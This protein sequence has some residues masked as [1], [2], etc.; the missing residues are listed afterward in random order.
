LSTKNIEF[1]EI[2]ITLDE[3]EAFKQSLKEKV[4]QD[5]LGN[6]P[7]IFVNGQFKGVC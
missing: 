1:T 6:L 4:P 2:D 3:N 5:K 7:Y